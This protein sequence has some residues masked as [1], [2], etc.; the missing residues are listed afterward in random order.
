MLMGTGILHHLKKCALVFV[1]TV[2]MLA[3]SMQKTLAQGQH[4]SGIETS[5][6]ILRLA[7]PA[8]AFGSTLIWRDQNKSTLRFAAAMGT[9]VVLTYSLKHIIDKERPNGEKYSF[10][11][12]HASVAFTGAAFLD[13]R[14]GWKVGVPAYLPAGY[15][16]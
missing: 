13:R 4:A 12:G 9:S 14:F 15:T 11:S 3:A 6:N 7:L 5:G 16:G 2:A 10:P 1:S 8:S